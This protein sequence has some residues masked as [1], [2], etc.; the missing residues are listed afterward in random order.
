MKTSNL[1][2]GLALTMA[3]GPALAQVSAEQNASAAKAVEQA[4]SA[5]GTFAIPD[6]PAAALLGDTEIA[7]ARPQSIQALAA[8]IARYRDKG[9]EV[10]G[11]SL[12]LAPALM[13]AGKRITY[14]DYN[15]KA[16]LRQ[17]TRMELSAGM[18][19]GAADDSA[20]R[21]VALGLSFTPFDAGDPRMDPG[22]LKCMNA[23][24]DAIK[25]AP[26]PTTPGEMSP[27]AKALFDAAMGSVPTCL[28]AAE[29]AKTL[30]QKQR[31]SD[32]LKLGF[33]KAW[34]S[35]G[36]APDTGWVDGGWGVW[37]AGQYSFVSD[38]MDGPGTRLLARLKRSSLTQWDATTMKWSKDREDDAT[39]QL[40]T[41]FRGGTT[42][43]MAEVGYGRTRGRPG[44]ERRWALGVEKLIMADTWLVLTASSK[45]GG[46]PAEPR[47]SILGRIKYNFSSAPLLGL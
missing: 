22:L 40:R 42:D 25:N 35:V 34:A 44:S 33:G 7:I 43:L 3:C 39:L 14:R 16:W 38:K 46:D 24:F 9:K 36:T 47:S 41:A 31:A 30:P 17:L 5:V 37:L 1:L 11:V 10:P 18:T 19:E 4:F 6:S 12:V 2:A 26:P 15:D 29:L 20:P 13:I 28:Q 21:R 27:D 23:A 8:E 45:S 32:S